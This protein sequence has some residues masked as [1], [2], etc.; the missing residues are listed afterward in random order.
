M[1]LKTLIADDE[2]LA[3]ERLRYLLAND[4]EIEITEEC[5][6]G[7]EVVAALKSKPIDLVFLDIQMP[8]NT[9]FEVIEEV[10]PAHMPTT[11]FVTAY[12]TYALKAFEVH[13][14]DYLTKPVELERIRSALVQVK[15]RI[16][17]R[18]ALTLHTQLS[19]L[20]ESLNKESLLK[21]GREE[22]AYIQR[23]LVPNGTRDSI[24]TVS[25]IEWIEAADYYARLHVGSKTFMLRETI[26]QLATLLDPRQ[27]VRIQRSAIVNIN[28]VREILRDGRSEGW[29]VLSNGQRLRMSKAGWKNF[30]DTTRSVSS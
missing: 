17:A 29:V 9:G 21:G 18:N 3:R 12:N 15:E 7:D 11:I 19:S 10:G 23:L 27:F 25:E 5:R 4:H 14:L 13:A 28:Q 8:G 20:L 6:N 30:L 26:K 24:V 2:P 1:K 16:A 22:K